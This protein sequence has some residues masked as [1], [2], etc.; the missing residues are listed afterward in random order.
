METISANSVT[1]IDLIKL[2]HDIASLNVTYLAISVGIILAFGGAFYLFNFRPLQNK[3]TKQGD[4]IYSEKKSNEIKF[5]QLVAD[6]KKSQNKAEEQILKL[7]EDLAK[8]FENRIAF[9]E[10]KMNS[11]EKLAQKEIVEMKRNADL[12]EL[13]NVWD[14]QYMWGLG[15][16]TVHENALSTLIEYTEKSNK[17]KIAVVDQRT[18][19]AA[20]NRELDALSKESYSLN[21][22]EREDRKTLY[23]E[24]VNAV[25]NSDIY[26]K[27]DLINKAKKILIF[28]K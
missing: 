12:I 15:G 21:T 26:S 17:K 4:R 11:L 1:L 18:L 5:E 22:K 16:L 8:L 6:V 28:D 25:N 14:K 23:E 13:S 19:S 2:M 20:L 3:I 10:E 7:K 9:A 24:L 27:A